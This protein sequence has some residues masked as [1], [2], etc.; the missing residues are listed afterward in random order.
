MQ[1]LRATTLPRAR[2]ALRAA[3]GRQIN[4]YTTPIARERA[5]RQVGAEEFAAYIGLMAAERAALELSDLWWVTHDM[6]V[7]AVDA[8]MSAAEQDRPEWQPE[9]A[10]QMRGLLVWDGG[11]PI[12][13]A[14][15]TNG[16][17]NL[18]IDAISWMPSTPET[19]HYDTITGGDRPLWVRAWTR[20]DPDH[21]A[22]ESAPLR[23]VSDSKIRGQDLSLAD[24][25]WA[26]LQVT[27]RLA[28]EPK[29][30]QTRPATFAADGDPRDTRTRAVPDVT[31]VDLRTVRDWSIGPDGTAASGDRDY[32]HR[33]IVRGHMRTYHVGPGGQRAEKR[34]IA[35]Y[36][37][38]PEGA[39][40]IPKETVWT[41]RR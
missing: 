17:D 10:D 16:L 26:V 40:L 19:R 4:R 25:V 14:D 18:I 32:R 21:S 34:W 29:A 2:D 1:P 6:T 35:P 39:P 36:V 38:G 28:H 31:V 22:G 3:L 24:I 7:L 23:A 9:S 27:M 15:P 20:H 8:Y 11:L 41:W 37:A 5:E 30:A 12:R 13:F 33:W